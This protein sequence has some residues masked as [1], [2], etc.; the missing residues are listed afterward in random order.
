MGSPEGEKGKPGDPQ[1]GGYR[2]PWIDDE[3]QHEATVS[4]FLIA[5]YEVTRAQW[6]RLFQVD[7][8]TLAS[9][10]IPMTLPVGDEIPVYNVRM[11]E[12]EEFCETTGLSLPSEAQWEYACRAGK[13]GPFGGTGKLEEMSWYQCNGR[14]R[15]T[16]LQRVGGKTPNDFGLYDMHG[17][18]TEW[19]KDF[20]DPHFYRNPEAR[21]PDPVCETD[22]GVRVVRGGS[23]DLIWQSH[24]SGR[25]IRHFGDP[26]GQKVGLRPVFNVSF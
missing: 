1:A 10:G 24:R 12:C 7:P 5:K 16:P 2:E 17:N 26:P 13:A 19:C 4:P 22:T 15:A 21:G 25:R 20:Y 3:F 9:R 11:E 18:V 14:N 6:R 23:A 8:L